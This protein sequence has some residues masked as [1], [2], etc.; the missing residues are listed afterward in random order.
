MTGDRDERE[1]DGAGPA[2]P[3][4]LEV[5]GDALGELAASVR[6]L[7][8]ATVKNQ[9]PPEV[10]RAASAA[11]RR[12]S[13]SLA[14]HVPEPPP[15]RYP[16]T[17]AAPGVNGLF[18]YDFVLGRFNPVAVPIE[19]E[20]CDPRA[21]G[22]V[23]FGTAYEGPPGCVH[24]AV[25]AAA[26]DQVLNAVNLM[27]GNPGPTRSLEIR[28]RKPTP[29]GRNLIFEGWQERVEGREVFAA[30]RLLAGD[31]ITAE[32]RGVFVPLSREQVMRLLT[33]ND[34]RTSTE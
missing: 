20:W 1:T 25:I 11:V 5:A 14:P 9:A 8:D 13:A 15:P 30:G 23:S 21:V 33:R 26:F 34:Q 10:L 19:I 16:T 27:R 17:P 18:P 28:Y 6:S 7:I 24:G 4:Y 3:S 29:L 31:V 12:V 22:R 32:A 2:P